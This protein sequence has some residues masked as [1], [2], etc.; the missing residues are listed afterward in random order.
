MSPYRL[1]L[2]T[3]MLG[4]A[5]SV[6]A[7]VL[8][9]ASLCVLD[10]FAGNI[11]ST[12][13][14]IEYQAVIRERMGHL[15]VVPAASAGDVRLF[16]PEEAERTRSLLARMKGIALVVPEISV[17]GI[18]ASSGHSATFAGQGVRVPDEPLVPGLQGAP[19][20][21]QS[22]VGN[23]VA[24][25]QP[26]AR[27][28]ALRV[29]SPLTLTAAVA[30]SAPRQ[31]IAQVVD[32]YSLP[33]HDDHLHSLLM[34][35]ELAQD[36]LNTDRTERFV[37]YLSDPALLELQRTV[38][39]AALRKAGIGTEVRTWQELSQAYIRARSASDLAFDSIA[40]MVFAVIAATVAATMS[41]N[42][43][44]RRR[45]VATLRA[46]GMRSHSVFLMLVTEALGMAVAGVAVSLIASGVVA[47]IINRVTVQAEAQRAFSLPMP[48]ELDLNRMLMAVVTVLAVALMAALVP[49]FKAA[50][51]NVA[52][53]LAA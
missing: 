29:G 19:G 18:A 33:G 41:I 49:A 50:R 44:E 37:V 43:L 15:S 30:D 48:V 26:K 24:I 39:A 47:W 27:A 45:E 32:V 52:S 22:P 53:A 3:L 20:K 46:L 5:R 6:L 51:A 31:V 28:L 7:I 13:A 11:A 1:A 8:I 4:R 9:G 21:L 36:L 38:V 14:G 23:G 40:G 17:A 2:R 16:G 25:S 35:L 42:A 34:P 10:L 12:R